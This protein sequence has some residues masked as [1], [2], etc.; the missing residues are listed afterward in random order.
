MADIAGVQPFI[1]QTRGASGRVGVKTGPADHSILKELLSNPGPIISSHVCGGLEVC[2]GWLACVSRSQP[3]YSLPF[4]GVEAERC[5][6]N[7]DPMK[8]GML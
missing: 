6:D 7:D 8:G 5:F 4:S 3:R 1:C 2:E